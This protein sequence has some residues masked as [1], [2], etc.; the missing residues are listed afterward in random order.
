MFYKLSKVRRSNL[1]GGLSPEIVSVSRWWRGLRLSEREFPIRR[2]LPIA[3]CRPFPCD[4]TR[5]CSG[6]FGDARS[7]VQKKTDRIFLRRGKLSSTRRLASRGNGARCRLRESNLRAKLGHMLHELLKVD[8]PHVING[9][10]PKLLLSLALL[11]WSPIARAQV[12]DFAPAGG[13]LSGIVRIQANNRPASQVLVSL[14]S[15]SA[16]ISRNVLTDVNGRFEIRGL[17]PDTYEIVVEEPGY[18]PSRTSAQLGDRKSV[19]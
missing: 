3:F 7:F 19:V 15:G 18:A 4:L 8:K 5:S 17:P 16:G 14:R 10:L 1:P 9:L 13:E 2:R 6:V 11:A 12:S